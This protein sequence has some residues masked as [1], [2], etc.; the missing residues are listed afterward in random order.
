M[1]KADIN[2][3]G[4]SSEPCDDGPRIGDCD[5][6]DDSDCVWEDISDEE[7]DDNSQEMIE[8]VKEKLEIAPESDPERAK[9]LSALGVV[10]YERY[11]K[12]GMMADLDEAILHMRQVVHL[13]PSDDWEPAGALHHLGDLLGVRYSRTGAMADLESAIQ[14]TR[15]AVDL[16]RSD[17]PDQAMVLN[18]LGERLGK[19]FLGTGGMADLEEAIQFLKQAVD[20]APHDDPCKAGYL[21]SLGNQLSEQYLRT[22]G[23]AVLDEAISNIQQAVDR[24]P[25]GH[26]DWVVFMNNLGA[27]FG[28][29][30]LRTGAI[31]DLEEAIRILRQAIGAMPKHH[32]NLVELLTNLGIRLSNRY[33][34][35]KDKA[36]LEEAIQNLERGLNSTPKD[37]PN[38]IVQLDVLA[39]LLGQRYSETRAIVDLNEAIQVARQAV[40]VTPEAHRSRAGVLANLGDE[41]SNLY[42]KEEDMASLEEAITYLR[43]AEEKMPQDSPD[44]SALLGNLGE[45]LNIRHTKT[46]AIKDYQDSVVYYQA[47]LNQANSYT[48]SRIWAGKRMLRFTQDLQQAY[49]AASLTVS[50]VPRLS[51]RSLQNSDR[52]HALSQVVGLASDAAALALQVG[53]TPM[54]ALGLLE[55]GRGVLGT[56]LEEV[57]TDILDLRDR[58]SELAEQFV[59]LRDELE[60]VATLNPRLESGNLEMSS[61]A[62]EGRRYDAGKEFNELVA[63]I[64]KLPGFK[65]FLLPPSETEIETA[66]QCGPIVVI[67]VSEYRCDALLV[68][69]HQIQ[70]VPLTQLSIGEVKNKI[71]GGDLGNYDVLEWLWD[72]VAKPI[73]DVLGF[74]QPPSSDESWPHVW[75]IPTGPLSKFPLH[76]AGYHSTRSTETVLD[77][78]MSSYG[79]S[80]KAIIYGRRRRPQPA[81]SAQALLVAMEH[82][83]GNYMLPFATKEVA[84]VGALCRSIP[85]QLIEPGCRRQEVEPHLR[86][87]KIFHF[88]GHGATDEYDAS[89][90]RLILE[91]G[92]I[93]VAELLEINLTD[94]S[95]FL[96]YLSAC[97]TG[98][99]K[100][101]RSV[102]ESIHLISAFQLAGFRHVIGTLWEVKD[103]LCV[104]MA[105]ITYE[106]IRDGAMTDESVCR[107]LHHA[108]RTLRDQWVEEQSESEDRSS[109]L[110][111]SLSGG[112]SSK[113]PNRSPPWRDVTLL[114][115]GPALWVPYIHFGV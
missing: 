87:C 54:I 48:L 80:V 71:R 44:R 85:L 86:D 47:A 6:N 25:K 100:D 38:R 111:G 83:P 19:R 35:T 105:R 4:K 75:W 53:Q 61:Q 20:I 99:I 1:A 11:L 60:T 21:N 58:D 107:G 114:E 30:Y 51:S 110:E 5:T 69:P 42:L 68:Q 64:Q 97:G 15:K 67:N 7:I 92:T 82:T 89:N 115:A 14:C 41:L 84:M 28:D 94:R 98:R 106:G 88:A 17:S 65:N 102:D 70:V 3:G 27:N 104:E 113:E 52:Q 91:D 74:T 22:G 13:P 36:D 31:A 62:R 45:Q 72:K 32:P 59:R 49:A 90:S 18:S 76:A 23:I 33:S 109:L 77:R 9:L 96:A 108:S 93:K 24:I 79:S 66:A 56:S 40:D 101:E 39:I 10:L 103:E 81:T 43:Q 63:K 73:L 8:Y 34:R 57:R 2:E 29:R 16:T 46:G 12:Q 78:V 112:T 26:L 95:P 37:H 55:Q 50:L